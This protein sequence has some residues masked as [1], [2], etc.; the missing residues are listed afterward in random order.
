MKP[1]RVCGQP[2]AARAK[3]CPHCGVKKPTA[4]K[5]EA[6]LDATASAAFKLGMLICLLAVLVVACIAVV[7]CGSE[8]E[9]E[10]WETR[11]F[12]D[13]AECWLNHGWDGT[14]EDGVNRNKMFEYW[15]G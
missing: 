15:C 14:V 3:T 4:T 7:A 5:I 13:E 6:G 8:P 11:G 10:Q 1:C 2:V 12:E 9:P